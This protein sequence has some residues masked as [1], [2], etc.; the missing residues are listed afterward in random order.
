MPSHLVWANGVEEAQAADFGDLAKRGGD[1]LVAGVTHALS[2]AGDAL[3]V[4]AR[5]DDEG[6]AEALAI[7]SVKAREGGDRLG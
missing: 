5:A 1:L 4:L 6:K 2:E 3:L 7:L